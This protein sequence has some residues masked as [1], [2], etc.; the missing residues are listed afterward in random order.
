MVRSRWRGQS[1]CRGQV[2]ASRL[3]NRG[4]NSLHGA[5]LCFPPLPTR[6]F[7]SFPAIRPVSPTCAF[8]GDPPGAVAT[9][10]STLF[11]AS[12]RA[13]RPLLPCARRRMPVVLDYQKVVSRLTFSGSSSQRRP[14]KLRES[15]GRNETR[16]WRRPGYCNGHQ[17]N[18]DLPHLRQVI[19]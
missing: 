9:A 18:S 11:T 1:R 14:N 16:R 13:S 10:V 7:L 5:I 8:T 3:A 12:A 19:F 6:A 17:A 2:L 15:Q 4:C